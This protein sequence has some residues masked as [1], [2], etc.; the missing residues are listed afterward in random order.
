MKLVLDARRRV[1]SALIY[2]AVLVVLSAGMIAIM[3]IYV[4]PKF[5]GF[6]TDLDA[7]LP[8]I[9]HVMLGV[10]NVH[11]APTGC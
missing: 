5:M 4:V 3:T 10:S 1:V 9:T 7:D 11:A 2:P 6:F 8:L